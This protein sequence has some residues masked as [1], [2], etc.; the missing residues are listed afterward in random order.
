[1]GDILPRVV[2]A[3]GKFY[4]VKLG[5]KTDPHDRTLKD[6]ERSIR[7]RLSQDKIHAKE[8]SAIDELRQQFPVKIDEQALSTVQVDLPS[9]DGGVDAR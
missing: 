2:P 6:A 1:M 7:V 4:V 9:L 5:S 3:R 8:E